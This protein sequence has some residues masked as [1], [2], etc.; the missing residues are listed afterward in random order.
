MSRFPRGGSPEKTRLLAPAGFSFLREVRVVLDLA[1]LLNMP[2]RV[3]GDFQHPLPA[4]DPL[5][6]LAETVGAQVVVGGLD[7]FGHGSA[8]RLKLSESLAPVFVGV[9]FLV[10]AA[11]FAMH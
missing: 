3:R 9:D 1:N 6:I 4:I 2:L 10:T 11:G 7:V 5:S 8:E